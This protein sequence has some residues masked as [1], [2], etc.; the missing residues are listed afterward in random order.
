MEP[1]KVQES[2][3]DELPGTFILNYF[4]FHTLLFALVKNLV[5][6]RIKLILIGDRLVDPANQV[7]DALDNQHPQQGYI[8]FGGVG[9]CM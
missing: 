4:Y 1:V 9:N 6:A 3:D 7:Q 2:R 5:N 8:L